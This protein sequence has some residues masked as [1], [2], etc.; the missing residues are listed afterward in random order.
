MTKN[1]R[2]RVEVI[3]RYPDEKV[4][5]DGGKT[6]W[7]KPDFK[8]LSKLLT[9]PKQ[10]AIADCFEIIKE[11][12]QKLFMYETLMG[13]LRGEDVAKHFVEYQELEPERVKFAGWLE[14]NYPDQALTALNKLKE[15]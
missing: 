1:T 14:K 11:V 4:S 10:E 6:W 15:D 9:Q 7:C 12:N 8:Q 5:V 2:E 13:K 3:T